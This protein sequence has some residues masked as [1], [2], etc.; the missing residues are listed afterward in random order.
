ML[1]IG[2][3]SDWEIRKMNHEFDFETL[4]VLK[5]VELEKDE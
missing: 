4:Y 2:K 5:P 1:S 3:S